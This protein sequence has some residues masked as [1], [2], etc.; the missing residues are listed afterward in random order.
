VFALR[1]AFIIQRVIVGALDQLTMEDAFPWL[2]LDEDEEIV[3]SGGPRVHVVLWVGVPALIIPAVLLAVWP[4]LWAG[5]VG[6]LAWVAVTYPA[7]LFVQ[8]VE[9]V[10]SSKYVYTKWGVLGIS[11]KQIG[12]HNIQDTTLT[13]GFL[14]TQADYGTVSFSTAGGDGAT[15]AFYLVDEP[16]TAK[17]AADR[18]VSTVKRRSPTKAPQS[19][20]SG[21]EVFLTELRA[22]R[23]AAQRIDERLEQYGES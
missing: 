14:G 11:V 15:L 18:Q 23:K 7:Y 19:D 1:E 22:T 4:T 2:A 16:A 5:V 20:T 9:Y 10:V 6:L 8:N 17:T 13:Q 21:I 3:W 12:L